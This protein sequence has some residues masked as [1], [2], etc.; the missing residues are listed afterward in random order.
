MLTKFFGPLGL[1]GAL[2]L[3]YDN[4]DRIKKDFL[5][6]GGMKILDSYL[7]KLK[8]IVK[9]IPGFIKL[10]S[11]EIARIWNELMQ[12]EEFKTGFNKFMTF[13]VEVFKILAS[14][15]KHIFIDM[16]SS[17]FMAMKDV[18]IEMPFGMPDINLGAAF[19][20]AAEGLQGMRTSEQLKDAKR[21]ELYNTE[22]LQFKMKDIAN[23]TSMDPAIR[24]RAAKAYEG[25][26]EHIRDL[27]TD[28]QK[29]QKLENLDHLSELTKAI[30]K[31]IAG[32]SGTAGAKTQ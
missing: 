16:F 22:K 28:L 26:G 29:L 27:K 19:V 13:T 25:L 15:I 7:E 4:W 8:S 11:T 24:D 12:D 1:A 6:P 2:V 17:I 10:V 30:N 9:K 23:T 18:K 21:G 32:P 20:G 31:L 5:G 14:K 3:L